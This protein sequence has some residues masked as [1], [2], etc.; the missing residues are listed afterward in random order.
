MRGYYVKLPK[1]RWTPQWVAIIT[2][3]LLVLTV[4]LVNGT[5]MGSSIVLTGTLGTTTEDI[6]MSFYASTL[7]IVIG[8]PLQLKIRQAMTPKTLIILDLALQVA[9]SLVCGIAEN[10]VVITICSFFLGMLK[11]IVIVQFIVL[12]SQFFSPDNVR[13]EYLSWFFPIIFGMGQVSMAFTAWLAYNYQWQYIYFC[14]AAMILLVMALIIVFFRDMQ[15]PA[16]LPLKEVNYQGVLL[17]SSAFMFIVH[18][19]IYGQTLDWF[20]SQDI[21][22]SVIL[23]IL[24]LVL[25]IANIYGAR[26]T[27]V[28][29]KVLKHWK[30][31]LG[32]LFMFFCM[33]FNGDTSLV[34]RYMNYVLGLDSVHTYSVFLWTLPG[35]ALAGIIAFWWFRWQRWRFRYLISACMALYAL[36]FACVYFGISPSSRYEMLFLPMIIKGMAMMILVIAFSVYAAE[37]LPRDLFVSNTFFLLSSRSLLTPVVA[38]CFFTNMLTRLQ[39]DAMDSLARQFSTVDEVAVSRWQQYYN[40]AVEAGSGYDEAVLSANNSLY[41]VLQTQGMLAGIKTIYGWLLAAALLLAVISAFIHFHE[42][43]KVPIVKT[44]SDMA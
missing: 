17:A 27:Y 9:L 8:N 30:T 19:L 43:V 1:R 40:S 36:Y 38:Y 21:R 6:M 37:D 29:L 39:L 4:A 5:Y 23:G 26:K 3:L 33:F 20:A 15:K 44:G 7:G 31:P 2:M 35:Y 10:I 11:T 28:S 42:T 16:L 34:N 12:M 32:C 41:A 18:A 25:F 22:V 14:A 13:S 24:L